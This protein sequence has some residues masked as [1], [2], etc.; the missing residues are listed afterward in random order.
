MITH[1]TLRSI[2]NF[3]KV[4]HFNFKRPTDNRCTRAP[5]CLSVCAH[6]VGE[7]NHRIGIG[8]IATEDREATN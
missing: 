5:V 8:S 7:L 3:Q 2:R 1:W 4:E 6:N